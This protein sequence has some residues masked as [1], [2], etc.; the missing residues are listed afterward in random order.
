MINRLY[1]GEI[2]HKA[3]SH[4]GQHQALSESKIFAAVQAR[5]WPGGPDRS[6][7]RS[8]LSP[9]APKMPLTRLVFDDSGE[10]MSPVS[11]RQSHGRTYRYYVSG[12]HLRSHRE[13]AGSLTRVPAEALEPAGRVLQRVRQHD[14][15]DLWAERRRYFAR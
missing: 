6:G 7:A 11:V 3:V 13:T 9:L 5:L 2:T 14:A 8:G 10:R 1:L 15:P 12:S 4:R